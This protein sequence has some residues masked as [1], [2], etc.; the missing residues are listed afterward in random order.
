MFLKILQN[1]Q[2]TLVPGSLFK[3]VAACTFI[4]KETPTQMFSCK[5]YKAFKSIYFTE[6]IRATASMF[7]IISAILV[8]ISFLNDSPVSRICSCKLST[9]VN[10]LAVL[11][12]LRILVSKNFKISSIQ[13]P[14]WSS[15]KTFWE[16]F[17][18]SLRYF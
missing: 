15:S 7:C 6:L 18:Q 14:T 4:L 2:E 10:R 8:K 11:T 13:L 3:N 12:A 5:F 1:S 16:I 17:P 9:Y